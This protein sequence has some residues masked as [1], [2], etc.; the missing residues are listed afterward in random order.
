MDTEKYINTLETLN[1]SM[2]ALIRALKHTPLSVQEESPPERELTKEEIREQVAALS[3]EIEAEGRKPTL[4]ECSRRLGVP[5]YRVIYA[6]K[7][8]Q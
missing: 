7:D 1:Q 5:Y 4:S 8:I 2:G 6:M 3:R